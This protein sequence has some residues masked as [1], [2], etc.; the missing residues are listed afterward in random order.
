MDV[1]NL[2]I[3]GEK[4]KKNSL[5]CAR[6]LELSKCYLHCSHAPVRCAVTPPS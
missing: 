4:K 1:L 2:R 6:S 5:R 3:A